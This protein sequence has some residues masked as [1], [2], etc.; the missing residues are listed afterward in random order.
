[1]NGTEYA[2][3]DFDLRALA[4]DRHKNLRGMRRAMTGLGIVFAGFLVWFVT[5][6]LRLSA[7]DAT[8]SLVFAVVYAG[9]VF[10]VALSIW[11]V[12][13]SRMGPT[14]L[15]IDEAGLKLRLKSGR[16]DS[17][18]W[19]ELERGVSLV[20][21][22]ASPLLKK[23]T[24]RLWELRRW[25]RP[26]AELS[27]DAFEAI[28]EAATRHELTVDSAIPRNSRLG[29]CRIVRFSARRNAPA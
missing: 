3:R 23:Y 1:M 25:N 5:L 26:P 2:A 22:S 19:E 21:Y 20:D 9:L 27:K 29:P 13:M 16:I 18:R 14:A 24:G 6:E 28:V 11:A 8:Q 15:T 12:W 17:L 10:A 4:A 7:L